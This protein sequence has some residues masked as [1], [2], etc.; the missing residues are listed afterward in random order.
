[1]V[2]ISHELWAAAI[3]GDPS[4]IGKTIRLN[5]GRSLVIGILPPRFQ[6]TSQR[7]VLETSG[8]LPA[9]WARRDL[10]YLTISRGCET[11]SRSRAHRRNSMHSRRSSLRRLPKPTETSAPWRRR[12]AASFLGDVRRTG[13]LLAVAVCL[14]LL[15][16]LRQRGPPDPV[17]LRPPEF[18]VRASACRWVP[19][20]D[21][22]V[23]QFM[24]ES[25]AVAL[26]GG[27]A[28][29]AV[30]SWSL[31]ALQFLIPTQIAAFT[32]VSSRRS[33]VWLAMLLATARA[34][35]AACCRRCVSLP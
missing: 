19:A 5:E 17:A 2:L 22:L 24:T 6:F 30:A 23:R 10:R 16:R 21:R 13:A 20:A 8:L 14:V 27:L 32:E 3:R 1:M 31:Q 33:D 4:L 28:G 34:W 15:D 12:F 18:G 9:T 11:T 29:F 7:T 26:A 25:L 35:S